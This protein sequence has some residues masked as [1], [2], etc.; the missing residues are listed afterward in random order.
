MDLKTLIGPELT[1]C[2]PP[3]K[4]EIAGLTADS[5]EVK[6]GWLFAAIPG[7]KA[8]GV[9]FI[10]EAV[11]KGAAAVLVAGDQEVS[12]P[13]HVAVLRT[14]EPR[15]A[16]ALLAARFYPD[17]PAVAVAV[18]GTSGKTSVADFTRQIFAALGR[19]AA[20]LGTIGL[21]KPDGSVYGGLTTPDPVSLHRTLAELA[22]EGVTHLAFEASSHGLDQHRLDGVRLKAAAF[23]N[24]GRDHLDYHPTM[25]AYLAAKL[26]LFTELLPA[27]G[28][29]VINA[30]AEHAAQVIAAARDS[31]RKV[32]TVGRGGETLKLE[33]LSRD[34]FAQRLLVRHEGRAHDIALPLPGDYQASNALLAAGLAIATG[35]PAVD[36]LP[37]L[38]HLK[39]VK[40]RLEIAGRVR[41]G[42]IVIDYAHKPDA[43]EAALKALR[44]F[45]SG[46]IICVFGCGGDRDKGKRPIMGQIAARLANHVIVTDDNPRSERPEIIRAEILAGCPGSREIGDRAEAIRAGARLLGPGDVLLVA[47]KGHETGQIVGSV[48]LPFSDHEAVRNALSEAPI[49]V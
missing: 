11:A 17:Q 36:V 34:G 16:L 39:G 3:G 35:E 46:R 15:H 23:T 26:R 33:R 5:R 45:A 2:A 10:P 6:P 31:G 8:D 27:G 21:V 24:L 12:V 41:G 48:I 44:E 47:G 29:A 4:T 40:G 20:S 49:D 37:A 30:D 42:L 13:G 28:T 9:R 43:L 38:T 32:M 18:T 25:E 19:S 22:G 1:V 7:S 14:A